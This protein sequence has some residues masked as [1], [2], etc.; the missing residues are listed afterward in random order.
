MT[1][2][3][4]PPR[5]IAVISTIAITALIGTT[6]WATLSSGPVGPR[7]LDIAIAVASAVLVPVALRRPVAGGL[8]LSA[9]V[10]LSPVATPAATFAALNAARQR[11]FGPALTVAVAGV[12]GHAL[13]GLWRPFGGLSYGWWLLLMALAY[14]ALLGW[15]TWGQAR[16]ALMQSLVDRARRA[17]AEQGRRVSEARLAERTLIAREMHDVLAHRL[18]LLAT[19]AGALEYRPDSPPERLAAAAGIIRSGVHQALDELREVI[20]V[21]REDPADPDGPAGP[22]LG[23]VGRLVDEAREAGL[24]VGFDD[25]TDHSAEA[26]AVVGRTAYRVVQEGLTNARKHAAGQPVTVTLAGS[27][28]GELTIEL[29]NPLSSGL[30]ELPGAGVGLIG[31]T[32]RVSLAGGQLDHEIDADGEFRLRARLPWRT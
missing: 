10:I 18:S 3:R 2:D 28:G 24:A 31:L 27:P 12:V 23:D 32:E 21:L 7:W 26:T 9:L 11:R 8:L 29:H 16:V 1:L 30:P 14:A 25:R 19:Y 15:G 4:R 20:T 5:A 13:Q 22:G 6:L 17:E